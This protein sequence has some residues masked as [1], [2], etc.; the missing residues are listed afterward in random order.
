MK[1]KLVPIV[2]L[3]L[4]LCA[5]VGPKKGVYQTTAGTIKKGY[6]K[7]QVVKVL[8]QPHHM[9]SRGGVVA[10]YYSFGKNKSLF[11]YFIDDKL[12]DVWQKS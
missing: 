3:L 1:I 4:I 12:T 10:W 11:V 5:C 7:E 6:T 8:G 9:R 2:L